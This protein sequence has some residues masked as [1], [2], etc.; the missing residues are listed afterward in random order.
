MRISSHQLPLPPAEP[1]DDAHSDRGHPREH[2]CFRCC[3]RRRRGGHLGASTGRSAVCASPFF[4]H[5]QRPIYILRTLVTSHMR[6]SRSGP[7]P[8]PPPHCGG[9]LAAATRRRWR[10]C[11]MRTSRMLTSVRL[12]GVDLSG[13]SSS[14]RQV[15][16]PVSVHRCSSP[17]N[18][19]A[20][21]RV[22]QVGS[23]AQERR[24]HHAPARER[25]QRERQ[26][27][28]CACGGGLC[29]AVLL[30]LG[31]CACSRRLDRFADGLTAAQVGAEKPGEL[32]EWAKA[33]QAK[34]AEEA[35]KRAEEMAAAGARGLRHSF[36]LTL[37]PLDLFHLDTQRSHMVYQEC[38]QPHYLCL[39]PKRRRPLA[40][41]SG[42]TIGR[43]RRKEKMKTGRNTM[44]S[45]GSV[46][47]SRDRWWLA[48]GYLLVSLSNILNSAANGDLRGCKHWAPFA[49][50]LLAKIAPEHAA[51]ADS[52]FHRTLPLLVC[53][54][55]QASKSVTKPT[56]SHVGSVLPC[57]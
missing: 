31:G 11:W 43:M 26:G 18:V 49:I 38:P 16:I 40:T 12:M 54:G 30:A 33:L 39:Q 48:M 7:T 50:P 25:D 22:G 44:S 17:P 21:A 13:A 32:T 41:T 47:L 9:R 6:A 42:M 52:Y 10:L 57:W 19:L 20:R 35:A 45:N 46:V 51:I 8:T 55:H 15:I 24:G 37:P 1:D 36:S 14:R 29:L 4:P 5:G 27:P 23:R 3:R 2:G 56:V 34:Q 53:L 28:R